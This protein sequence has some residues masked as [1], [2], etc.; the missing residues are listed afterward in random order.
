VKVL[1][2]SS[3]QA[4]ELFTIH[5]LLFISFLGLASSTKSQPYNAIFSF[6]DSYAD[7]GNFV[8]LVKGI[9]PSVVFDNPQYGMTYFGRPTGR[10]SDGRLVIDFIGQCALSNVFFLLL[11]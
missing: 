1:C 2:F 7:T 9:L 11:F 5:F 3:S 10:S 6:G 4:M 8:K